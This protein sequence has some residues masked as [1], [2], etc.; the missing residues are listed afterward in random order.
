[1][2][3]RVALEQ[4]RTALER[5]RDDPRKRIVTAHHPLHGPNPEGPS[6]TIGGIAALGKLAAAQANAVLSGHIHTPFNEW[7]DAGVGRTQLIGAGTLSTRL[8][9]GAP[10]SYNVLT[11]SRDSAEVEVE[12][13]VLADAAVT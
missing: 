13:R 6:A 7:C 10:A 4:A 1:V 12:L 2:V 8:R 9:H 3:T 5:Y 11:I